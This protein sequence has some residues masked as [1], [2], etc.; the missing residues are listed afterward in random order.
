MHM[1]EVKAAMEIDLE[2]KIN[3]SVQYTQFRIRNLQI[4]E[5]QGTI[6][7]PMLTGHSLRMSVRDLRDNRMN[8]SYIWAKWETY[9][10]GSH[11][12][13]DLSDVRRGKHLMRKLAKRVEIPTEIGSI[14]K[15]VSSAL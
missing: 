3:V 8:K 6:E 9:K 5:L 15:R 7:V 4:M 14:R 13:G 11:G 1:S 2:Q 12:E 10:Q